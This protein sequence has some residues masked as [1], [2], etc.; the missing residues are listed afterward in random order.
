MNARGELIGLAYDGN[1]ESMAGAFY[2]HPNYNKCVCVDIR[3]ILWIIDKYAG[4]SH[5]LEEL[6]IHS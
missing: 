1:W 3:F 4:A 6:S 2:F 5:L